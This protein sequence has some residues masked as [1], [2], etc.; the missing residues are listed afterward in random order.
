VEHC[1][2]D[3][4]TY[5]QSAIFSYVPAQGY[6]VI[7]F[8]DSIYYFSH[9]RISDMLDRYSKYLARDGVFIVKSWLLKDR[10][11]DII[12]NI[13][14]EFDVLEKKL[15]HKSELCVIVPLRQPAGE[16]R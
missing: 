3:K 13:E 7:F 1:R 10:H 4:N 15:Y 2:A 8:G 12:R 11:R 9:E 6:D 5:F 14:N 16:L